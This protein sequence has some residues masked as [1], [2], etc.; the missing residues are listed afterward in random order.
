MSNQIYNHQT[1]YH[2]EEFWAGYDE[3][4][5]EEQM[6]E[7]EGKVSSGVGRFQEEER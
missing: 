6:K 5:D 3:A 4:R 1:D 2:R 7:D